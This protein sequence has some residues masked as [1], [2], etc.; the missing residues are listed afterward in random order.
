MTITNTILRNDYVANGSSTVFSFTFIVLSETAG[1]TIQVITTDLIGIETVKTQGVDYTV[2]LNDNGLGTITF[3]TAPLLNHKITLLSNVP[4]TQETD[5]IKAGTDKFPAESHEK[6]L[7]KLTLIAKQFLEKFNRIVSL[8]KNSTLSGIEFPINA[9][10]ANQI[11]AINNDGTNL[12]TKNLA[13]VGIAP[14]SAYAKTLLDDVNSSEARA[15]L[16]AQQLNANLTALAGLT[17]ALNKL[18]YFTSAGAMAVRD[19]FATTTTQGISFLSNPITIS[20]N[21][22]DANNDIDFTAGNFAFNDGSK[23]AVI[24]AMTKRL[25]A[26]WTAGTN[27]GGLDTGSKANST[28]YYVYAIHNP[29]SGVSDAIFSA[30]ATTPTLPSGY[31]KQSKALFA[32]KTDSG[33]NILNGKWYNDRSFY[34]KDDILEEQNGVTTGDLVLV[35]V[36]LLD[37]KVKMRARV[38]A[39]V[40]GAFP[41]YSIGRSATNIIFIV[42]STYSGGDYGSGEVP[43]NGNATIYRSIT[44]TGAFT[45]DLYTTGYQ[46]LN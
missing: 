40:V 3:T 45:S 17:G 26:S 41:N 28:W 27:Q 11:L 39:S 12:T 29:T 15:T 23:Q 36:P 10:N 7:D 14:V 21:A 2:Q 4:N 37:L 8:P 33:G 38:G 25:D 46:L 22:T 43:I 42:G 35:G 19:L 30:N 31:T 9:S 24:S 20:N 6:A 32:L 5:Y 16:D 34:F 18:F 13:D 44:S 1:Y